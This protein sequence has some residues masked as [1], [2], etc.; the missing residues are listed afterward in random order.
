MK[1]RRKDL[2]VAVTDHGHIVWSPAKDPRRWTD[3]LYLPAFIICNTGPCV[4]RIE[5][6]DTSPMIHN[7]T[8][9][10]WEEIDLTDLA[11]KLTVDQ[12]R[13]VAAAITTHSNIGE[14]TW[15]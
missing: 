15:T 9:A 13:V 1:I 6:Q 11:L 8:S 4:I 3:Y 12:Q 7:P 14:V 2:N 10:Q 5:L